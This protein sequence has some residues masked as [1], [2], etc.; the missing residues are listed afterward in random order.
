MKVENCPSWPKP[1]GTYY[2]HQLQTPAGHFRPPV[3]IRPI[4]ST[5]ISDNPPSATAQELTGCGPSNTHFHKPISGLFPGQCRIYRNTDVLNHV[6]CVKLSQ[7]FYKVP[8]FFPTCQWWNFCLEPIFPVSCVVFVVPLDTVPWLFR[9]TWQYYSTADTI[10]SIHDRMSSYGEYQRT[11]RQ[12]ANR[13][14]FSRLQK[15]PRYGPL[16]SAYQLTY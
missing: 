10:M 7:Y 5:L 1:T 13:K 15:G 6:T 8:I 16:Q 4:T 3:Y 11:D 2:T 14:V 9:S 12:P